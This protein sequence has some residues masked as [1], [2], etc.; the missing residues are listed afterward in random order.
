M[1]PSSPYKDSCIKIHG[2]EAIDEAGKIA[3]EQMTKHFLW[4]A[5]EDD[6]YLIADG[7]GVSKFLTR[8]ETKADL[9][10]R[11]KL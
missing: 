7:G 1:E 2:Q 3:R 9:C 8:G 6:F 11:K 10:F 5:K 4:S